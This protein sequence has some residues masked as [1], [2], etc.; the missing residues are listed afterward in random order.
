M[1]SHIFCSFSDV[2]YLRRKRGKTEEA[3]KI[4]PLNGAVLKFLASKC[5]VME[6]KIVRQ[7]GSLDFLPFK[8][9]NVSFFIHK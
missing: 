2:V 4:Q 1:T 7:G 3:S 8:T 9:W 5:S 6:K